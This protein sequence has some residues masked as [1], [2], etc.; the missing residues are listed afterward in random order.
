MIEIHTTD[1]QIALARQK[2]TDMGTLNNSIMN[3][4]GN[5]IGFLGEIVVYD[6]MK[7]INA[8]THLTNTYDYDILYDNKIK[9]DVKSKRCTTTPKDYYECSV[10]NYNTTQECDAYVFTRILENLSTVWILGYI[11]TTE[12]YNK[13]KFLK[14]GEIDPDNNYR[15]RSDCYNLAIRDLNQF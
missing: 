9:L 12:Y 15:V 2:S 10:A 3:G 4:R 11:N 5:I 8:N 7:K 13:A 1:Q 14:Q 6:F